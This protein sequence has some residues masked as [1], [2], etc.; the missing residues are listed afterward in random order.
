MSELKREKNKKMF[1]TKNWTKDLPLLE[2]H[3]YH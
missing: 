2:V 1:P 3:L